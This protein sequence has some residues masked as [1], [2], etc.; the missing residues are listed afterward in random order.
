[1]Q[2]LGLIF[3]LVLLFSNVWGMMLLSGFYW[4]NRWS[5]LAL[6][7]LLCVTLIYGIECYHGLG[8]SLAGLAAVGTVA[9]LGLIA[10]SLTAW[11]PSFVSPRARDRI[12]AWRREFG[13]RQVA[14]PLGIFLAVFGY[15]FLWR[16][17]YPNVDGSSEKIADL[18]YIVSYMSGTTIPVTDAWL[19]PYPST[20]YY[21]FQHYGA[22][23]M[24]RLL[25]LSPGATYNIALSLLIGLSGAAMAGAV[26][27]VARKAWVR[28]LVILGFVIGGSGM[29]GLIH[30]SEKNVTPW[31]S[32]RY[33]GSAQMDKAPLGPWLKEYASHF[34]P[35]ELPGEPF[36]YSIFLGDYHAPL[37]SYY[38][39]GVAVVSMILWARTRLLRYP[40]ILGAT[41]TWTLLAN[42]WGLP[43]L[44]LG[45]FLWLLGN[46]LDLRRLV[47]GI[48]IGAAAVWFTAWV[49]LSAFT[50]QAAGYN[51]AIRLVPFNEHTPPLL[52]FLFLLPT[53]ALSLLAMVS[54]DSIGKKLSLVWLS[55]LVFSEFVFVD[56]VYSGQY[57]RFNTSLK[58]WPWIAVGTLITVAPYILET[59][60]RKW[61]RWATV[62]FCAYPCLY[63]LDL[64][65]NYHT[66][67]KD[68]VGQI[69]GTQFLTKDEFARLELER[70]SREPL[71]VVIERL[72]P[73]DFTNTSVL[74]L[75]ARQHMWLGWM[76]HEMLW[77]AFRD[78]LRKR[79]QRVFD[80]YDAKLPDAGAWLAG[81]GVDYVLWYKPEDTRELWEKLNP[82]LS[83]YYTWCEIVTEVDGR[84]T[85]YWR[86]STKPF[87]P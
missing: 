57:D 72:D 83:A 3:T 65:P 1:M 23:L 19:Y 58:W 22:S 46:L 9:S 48:V 36:S 29:T 28:T 32:M 73:K 4:R 49:Y 33:I 16:F 75:F 53:I 66:G 82:Q 78:D 59:T 41:L 51:A 64:W 69:D 80:L 20:Q 55:F 74:P 31:S 14:L 47:P 39:L 35:Q 71:G 7:P 81:E 5:A 87:A 76:D 79:Q 27:L 43:L 13:L 2:H 62:F 68:S 30:L 8:P 42:T 60:R 61:V 45:I 11:E 24:G 44:A 34:P 38:L 18:S 85:G 86:R 56:D 67:P 50:A 84:R 6:G 25:L 26:C 15:A 70:L 77:R 63:I 17:T 52:F 37:A 12:A 54:G 10:L 21:S 40:V